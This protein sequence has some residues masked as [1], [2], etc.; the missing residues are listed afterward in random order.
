[1]SDVTRLL[2]DLKNGRASAFGQAFEIVY[3]DLRRAAER[4]LRAERPGHMLQA[5]ALVHEAYRRLA[6]REPQFSDRAHFLAVAAK[7]MR[8]VLIDHARAARRVKRGG[9]VEGISLDTALLGG[10]P[11]RSSDVLAVDDALTRL[12]QIDARAAEVTQMRFFGGMTAREVSAVL[13]VS[14][15]TVERDW[16]YARAWLR[17]ELGGVEQTDETTG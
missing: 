7:A 8:K 10:K 14:V 1:M 2:T 12:A 3:D 6:N 4:L 5:T 11:A 16:R 15:P 17:E 13:S 9:G